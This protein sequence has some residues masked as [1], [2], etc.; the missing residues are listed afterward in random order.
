MAP[1]VHEVAVWTAIPERA[2]AEPPSGSWRRLR[3]GAGARRVVPSFN[4][5][6]HCAGNRSAFLSA[7]AAPRVWRL[8]GAYS[9]GWEHADK[10]LISICC[11]SVIG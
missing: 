8:R 3:A 11:C 6:V 1:S 7:G 2:V 9:L 4:R 5:P 10:K